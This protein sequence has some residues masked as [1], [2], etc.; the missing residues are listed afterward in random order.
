[1]KERESWD[2]YQRAFSEM[3]S[4]TSTPHAPWHVIPANRKWFAHIAVGVVLISALMEID[5]RYPVLD[6]TERLAL[7]E[8]RAQ[9]ESE[10]PDGVPADPYA[11]KHENGSAKAQ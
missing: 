2:D 6:E 1:M 3:L 11:K 10:A 4:S 5:P 9:L 8:A 7:K